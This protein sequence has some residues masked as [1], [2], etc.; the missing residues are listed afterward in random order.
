LY[1]VTFG[2]AILVLQF[3]RI[4]LLFVPRIMSYHS[5]RIIDANFNRASE[6]LRVLE[7]IARFTLN[8]YTI[9]QQL[10]TMRHN[11]AEKSKSLALELLSQRNS[12][13]DV[14]ANLETHA[15]QLAGKEHKDLISVITANAKRVEQS[16][17]VIEELSRL[18]E[19]NVRIIP[20][21]IEQARF[22]LY[23]LEKELTSRILRSSKKKQLRGL[24]VILDKHLL[25]GKDE[26]EVAS[27]VLQGGAK[28]IQLRDKQSCK[29]DLLSTAGRLKDLCHQSDAIFIINDCL[30]LALAVDADGVHIGQGDLPLPIVRRE[31]P[32][33]KI[34]GCSA[35]T[36]PLALKAQEEG[37]DYI[38]SG[39]IFPST[40]KAD[41]IVIGTEKLK[42]IR[43]AISLPLV[44]I[45]GIKSDN[46][47]QVIAAGA[48]SAAVISAVLNT[49]NIESAVR[50][51]IMKIEKAREDT[52]IK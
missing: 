15:G 8:D 47:V 44:A 46:I 16:L 30:D 27:M 24:Y 25:A 51:L 43:Q 22:Q 1:I 50:N 49:E 19:I 20:L 13:H 35:R 42:Q 52:I 29:A 12:Q 11:L 4:M 26:I 23:T 32:I 36:I 40:T 9:S 28:I 5:L 33:D 37:A 6:G 3:I 38:A 45:G 10:K 31:L 14:G 34:I 2:Q 21:H 18:P 48:D 7:D 17:R 41:A 39:S